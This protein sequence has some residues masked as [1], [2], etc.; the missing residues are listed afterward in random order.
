[1]QYKLDVGLV[2]VRSGDLPKADR[3]LKDI[4]NEVKGKC[5]AFKNDVGLPGWPFVDRIFNFSADRITQH[6]GN[7]Y[8]FCLDLAML[9]RIQGQQDKMVQEYLSYVTQSSANIQYV[10][11]VMQALLT[12][13]EELESLE[14]SFTT[15]FSRTRMWRCTRTF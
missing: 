8:L 2:Y 3:Y 13:P 4:I 9:Y 10:K 14:R 6:L 7:P 5:S 12:K 1:M 11:N 15:K